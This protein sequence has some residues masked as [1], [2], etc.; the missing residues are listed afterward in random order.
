ME[1]GL[2]VFEDD[3]VALLGRFGTGVVEDVDVRGWIVKVS[4][5][6]NGRAMICMICMTRDIAG[7]HSWWYCLHDCALP[8]E[9]HSEFWITNY[10]ANRSRQGLK[11]SV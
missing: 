2:R 5:A 6:G 7:N 4:T 1:N 11:L 3:D 8:A 10:E 9:K